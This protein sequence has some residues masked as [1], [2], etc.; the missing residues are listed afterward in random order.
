MIQWPAPAASKRD[1]QALQTENSSKIFLI[2]QAGITHQGRPLDY[3]SMSVSC[4]VWPHGPSVP[5]LLSSSKEVDQKRVQYYKV[6]PNRD[7]AA[8]DIKQC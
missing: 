8:L 1:P 2:I 6:T 5:S 4:F 7:E 3:D